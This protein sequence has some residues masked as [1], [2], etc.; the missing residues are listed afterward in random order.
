MASECLGALCGQGVVKA[1]LTTGKL[2][3]SVSHPQPHFFSVFHLRTGQKYKRTDLSPQLRRAYPLLD[4]GGYKKEQG[5]L[6]PWMSWHKSTNSPEE[7]QRH[8]GAG[9]RE[10]GSRGG[11]PDQA[12]VKHLA[13]RRDEKVWSSGC[14]QCSLLVQLHS[15]WE[16][17][18]DAW[19]F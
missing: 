2:R 18:A 8:L 9:R 4:L 7:R 12:P 15:L 10:Q 14:P 1:S 16:I 6:W 3:L 13:Q 19:T 17:T 5:S 11:R